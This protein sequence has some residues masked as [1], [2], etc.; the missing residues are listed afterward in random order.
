MFFQSDIYSQDCDPIVPVLEVDLSADPSAIFFSP[1]VFRIGN[2]CGT[3][4][5]DVCIA[6][7]LT[8]HPD[9]EG[10]IF[11]ICDGAVPGGSMYYQIDC[12]P[13]TAVGEILCL[14]GEGPH[15]ITFCKPGNNENVY[16][17]SS[18]AEPDAGPDAFAS[19]GC[20]TELTSIGYDPQ[21]ITWNSVFPGNAGEYNNL[22]SC[23]TCENTMVTALPNS[24]EYVD[25][26]VCGLP[27]GGCTIT[28]E[29]NTVRVYFSSTLSVEIAP[30]EP[31]ICFGASQTSVTAI[32]SGGYPPYI[33]TWSN[34]SSGETTDITSAGI[35]SVTVNDASNCP[36]AEL[37]FEVVSYA[38]PLTVDA[39]ADIIV[40]NS[41]E[42]VQLN[43]SFSGIDSCIW[44]GGDGIFIPDRY[45]PL[46]QYQATAEEITNGSLQLQ[47][48]LNPAGDCPP[49]SDLLNLQ[50]LDFTD[51]ISSLVQHI[52]CYGSNDGSI[53]LSVSG[54]QGPYTYSW[55]PP[56]SNTNSINNL[57]PWNYSVEV[58]N[59]FGC[60]RI[61]EFSM[62]EPAQLLLETLSITPLSCYNGNDAA[63]EMLASG[64]TAPYSYQWS[65]PG[66]DNALE[67][68]L[69]AGTYAISVEDANNCT[70]T[71]QIEIE[72]P[73]PVLINSS[74]NTVTCINETINLLASASGGSTPYTYTWSNGLTNTGSHDVIAIEDIVYTVFAE[75]NNGCASEMD[76]IFI[77]VSDIAASGESENIS[78]YGANDGSISLQVDSE[79]GPVSYQWDPTAEN[80]H[81]LTQLPAGEYSVI[82][83]DTIGCTD[84]LGFLI[85]ESQP[86]TIE[87]INT[88]AVSCYNGSDGFAEI[89]VYGGT[90]PHSYQWSVAGLDANSASNLNAGDYSILVEDANGCSQSILFEI[91]SP[92]PLSLSSSGD[93]QACPGDQISIS[94]LA[95]GGSGTY[96]YN[97]NNG[98]PNV[99]EHEINPDQNEIYTVNVIDENDCTSNT[100]TLN[101]TVV[102]MEEGLLTV[103]G[104]DGICPGD[105][106]AIA[107]FYNGT[108]G[109][110]TYNWNNSLPANAGFHWISPEVSTVYTVNISDYCNNSIEL[111][112]P[113][114]VFDAPQ[115]NLPLLYAEGCQPLHVNLYDPDNTE[116]GTLHTWSID[117]TDIITGNAV[118]ITLNDP[119]L[120]EIM[121][122]VTN[123]QGCTTTGKEA[124]IAN[125]IKA[126]IAGF[127]ADPWETGIDDPQINFIN[128][129]TT[130]VNIFNWFFG[131]G[132]VS[133][134]SNPQHTYAD[135][136]FYS[137]QLF[138]ENVF[139]CRDTVLKYVRIAPVYTIII[140][141]AFTPAGSGNGGTYDPF[142]TDNN[143]FYPF[144]DYVTDFSMNIFNRW[145]ELIFES[146]DMRIGWDGTYRG[147]PCPQ[148][149]YVYKMK[150]SFSDGKKETRV[151]DIT[152]FR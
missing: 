94:A 88:Q 101:I 111:S 11:D 79:Y 148:D 22:L 140:P 95:S 131:D 139:G 115:L 84:S 122:I 30:E 56:L 109:P 49:A 87:M 123:A 65:V 2:C 51:S 113:V 33:F 58:T 67:E 132:E 47:L 63:A 137:V 50:F 38:L 105:S 82:F 93:V 90:S 98:V 28:P 133:Q 23:A 85:E 72:M 104:A 9:A 74:G 135:T 41:P 4:N 59:T 99:A 100:D 6:F 60:S 144:T 110:Y 107:A 80:T 31:A 112:I 108:F 7:N 91:D 57:F 26:E 13:P 16:C 76:S 147:Q 136:G 39:G 25:Y 54:N 1:S 69:E 18:I 145:G 130:D 52:S 138:V 53:A 73:N 127:Q 24:P 96:T 17:I 43:G 106:T 20:T 149:V 36:P 68:N 141:N 120:H 21:T 45:D 152:L 66:L 12:G 92:P 40:C 44:E 37:I 114:E 134:F 146:K 128:T 151:G 5:P 19:E 121:L 117:N 118:E 70:Q 55:D 64:G 15:H 3:A 42:P 119:G 143:V 126:P 78:C 103:E 124:V 75:D 116:P 48:S 125:V 97:W 83:T 14:S 35:Y 34:G 32:G 129:S 102:N 142:G 27:L 150:F 61:L 81:T 29:C 10:I 77:H 8:L 62:E 86:L 89:G 46:A 71:E